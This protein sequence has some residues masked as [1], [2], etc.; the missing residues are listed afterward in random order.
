MHWLRSSSNNYPIKYAPNP[1]KRL[2]LKSK[3]KELV[4]GNLELRAR[5]EKSNY[6]EKNVRKQYNKELFCGFKTKML[7]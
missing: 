1:D 4:L 7:L 3:N 2:S 5:G 6:L